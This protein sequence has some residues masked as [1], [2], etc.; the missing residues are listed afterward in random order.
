MRTWK[1]I[2]RTL[3]I[4]TFGLTACSTIKSEDPEKGVRDF[5][6]EFQGELAVPGDAVLKKFRVSQSQEALLAALAVLQNKDP[7]VQCSFNVSDAGL[8]FESNRIKV[9][10]P[11]TFTVRNIDSSSHVLTLWI[12]REQDQYK[13][14]EF[15]GEPFYQA[16]SQI[17]NRSQWQVDQ[18]L[19]LEQRES[20]YQQAHQLESRFDSVIWFAGGPQKAYF[21]VTKGRW[22]N[23]FFRS[24]E[25]PREVNSTMG[26]VDWY[27][28]VVI[29]PDYESVGAIGFLPRN[30]VEVKKDGKVGYFDVARKVLVAEPLY[31]MI[32]PYGNLC[33]VRKDTTYGWLDQAFLYHSGYPT[34]TAQQWVKTLAFLNEPLHLSA[35]HQTYCE[36]PSADYAGN[37]ILP[38]PSYLYRYGIFNEIE[39]GI[40]TTQVPLQGWTEYIETNGSYLQQIERA[41]AV[42]ITGVRERYLEGREE[43]YD[44]SKITF[45]NGSQDTLAVKN[46]RAK[47]V[48][49]RRIS[50][51]LLEIKGENDYGGFEDEPFPDG[52]IPYYSYYSITGPDSIAELTSNRRFPQTQYVKLDSS[53]LS[54]PF[55]IYDRETGEERITTFLSQEAL[56]YM[57]DEILASNGYRFPEIEKKQQFV[58]NP[59]YTPLYTDL[60]ECL[61]KMS[62]TDRHNVDYLNGVLARMAQPVI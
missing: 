11:T 53:Y 5:L 19:A 21:Y 9:F 16:F 38:M 20:I 60:E 3:V 15:D 28:N 13:I 17:R 24:E 57:R 12:T 58:Y 52:N 30:L 14:T 18:E 4:L 29:P 31:D 41:I 25:T 22:S 45:T 44:F 37:G 61:S 35:G 42:I 40:S 6:Q 49:L 50:E 62:P 34:R 55:R 46:L 48:T 1:S 10:L 39:Y 7:N 59:W 32:V 54:G 8:K 26:L 51:G 23:F 27:G 43:F 47:S 33:I 2:L 36:I 56:T